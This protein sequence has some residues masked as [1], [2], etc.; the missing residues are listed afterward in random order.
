MTIGLVMAARATGCLGS[1]GPV[2]FSLTGPAITLST[3]NSVLHAACLLVAMRP[4]STATPGRDGPIVG[5]TPAA[6]CAAHVMRGCPCRGAACYAHMGQELLGPDS[7]GPSFRSRF[8]SCM[9]VCGY[10]DSSTPLLGWV[11]FPQ[12]VSGH[13][14]THGRLMKFLLG[15]LDKERKMLGGLWDSTLSMPKRGGF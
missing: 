7:G 8:V 14:H 13:T 1:T 10:T 6:P 4:S 12:T 15:S 9:C 5:E 2:I 3:S 11:T